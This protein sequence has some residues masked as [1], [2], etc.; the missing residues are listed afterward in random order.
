MLSDN[1]QLEWATQ[2][3]SHPIFKTGE[4][5]QNSGRLT[6]DDLSPTNHASHPRRTS[7]MCFRGSDI[8]LAVGKELRIAPFLDYR[9]SLGGSAGERQ[10]KVI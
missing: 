6:V 4:A 5:E 7:R 1:I 8:I 2:F 9:S 10:Y 3:P